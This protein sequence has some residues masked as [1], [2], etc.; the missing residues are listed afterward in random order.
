MEL[1]GITRRDAR[2]IIANRPYRDKRDLVTRR[3]VTSAEY[4]SIRDQITAKP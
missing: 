4:A 3:I 2:R 1:P